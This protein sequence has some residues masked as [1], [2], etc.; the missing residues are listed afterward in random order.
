LNQRHSE[1][2]LRVFVAAGFAGAARVAWW[3]WPGSVFSDEPGVQPFPNETEMVNV[4]IQGSILVFNKPNS[5][6]LQPAG[7]QPPVTAATP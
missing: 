4:I 5:A 6:V 3:Y 7:E 1:I 2:A